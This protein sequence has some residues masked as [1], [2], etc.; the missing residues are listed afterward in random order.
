MRRKTSLGQSHLGEERP[1]DRWQIG[2]R[3]GLVRVKEKSQ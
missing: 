2:A 3:K 1:V